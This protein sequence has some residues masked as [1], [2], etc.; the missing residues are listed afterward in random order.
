MQLEYKPKPDKD[1][2]E[3]KAAG[4]AALCDSVQVALA[5]AAG[6]VCEALAKG[7]QARQLQQLRGHRFHRTQQGVG[8]VAGWLA[9]RLLAPEANAHRCQPA[10]LA[11]HAHT[12]V[13]CQ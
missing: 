4:I 12:F 1:T 2:L 3:G 5:V 7:G 6:R 8:D 10:V 9:G 13:T 11:K